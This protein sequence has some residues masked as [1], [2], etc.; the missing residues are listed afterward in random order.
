MSGLNVAI[1]KHDVQQMIR[2]EETYLDTLYREVFAEQVF[3]YGHS[4]MTISD[5][6]E[7]VR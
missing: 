6:I 3:P 7:V 5:F 2:D 1:S 4:H